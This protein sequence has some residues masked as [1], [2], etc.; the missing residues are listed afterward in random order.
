MNQ[1]ESASLYTD[2]NSLGE[3]RRGA[4]ENS[5]ETI[6]AVAQQFEAIFVQ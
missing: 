5:P 4:K 3:L 2:F 1:M 6:K